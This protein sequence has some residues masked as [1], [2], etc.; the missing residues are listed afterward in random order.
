MA[1][2]REWRPFREGAPGLSWRAID[3]ITH[4]V[5]AWADGRRHEGDIEQD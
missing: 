2:A 4:E 3:Q 5:E 1:C